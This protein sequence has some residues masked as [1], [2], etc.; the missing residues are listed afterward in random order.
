MYVYVHKLST[1]M[2]LGPKYN[3]PSDIEEIIRQ[4]TSCLILNPE[5]GKF[6]KAEVELKI[7]RYGHFCWKTEQGIL[8][9]GGGVRKETDTSEILTKTELVSFDGK[10]SEFGFNVKYEMG[11]FGLDVGGCG[12]DLEDGRYVVI[13]TV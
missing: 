2:V 3:K 13:G 11:G 1:V 7:R 12:I 5:S 8:L 9:I 4:E 6:R 10:S